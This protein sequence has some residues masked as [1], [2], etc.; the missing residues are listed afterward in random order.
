MKKMK[1]LALFLGLTLIVSCASKPKDP[2]EKKKLF[3]YEYDSVINPTPFAT[4]TEALD[5]IFDNNVLGKTTITI[6]RSEWDTMLKNYDSYYRN[7]IPVHADYMFEKG[8]KRWILSNAGFRLRGNTTRVRPQ[9]PDYSHSQGNHR[10]SNWQGL[11]GAGEDKYRQSSFKVSFDKFLPDDATDQ[12]KEDVKMAGFIKGVNLKRFQGDSAYIREIYSFDLLRGYGVWT[13]PRASYTRLFIQIFEDYTD[14]SYTLLN[15]GIYE[16]FEEIGKESLAERSKKTDDSWTSTKGNLWKC[17]EHSD[18]TPYSIYKPEIDIGIDVLTAN[19]DESQSYRYCL[20]SNKKDFDSAKDELVKWIEEL[21]AINV[22]EDGGP[23]KAKE[24][25]DSHMEVDLFLRTMA[26]NVILGMDD[27]YWGN[28]NNFY[29]YFDT[30]AKGSGK[31]YMIPFDY[32]H[33]FGNPVGGDPTNKNPLN[34]GKASGAR[35]GDRP[36]MEKM[37]AVPEYMEL[38]KKYLLEFTDPASR[39]GKEQSQERI[40]A[41]QALV[42]PYI[43][44]PSLIYDHDTTKR[45]IDNGGYTMNKYFLLSNPTIWEGKRKAVEKAI[46]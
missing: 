26:C 8:G 19:K 5:Y 39:F 12:Q 22:Y 38:Y 45:I 43:N 15:Y 37:I 3:E 4:D 29:L 44:S 35:P 2:N 17:Q 18:F 10:W 11:Q 42:E 14:G 30:S 33:T 27:D 13:A 32:D 6:P 7:E 23:E 1:F 31:L 46:K 25:F 9:G 28:G 41:W 36:L 40:K 20:K 16:M 24:W 34:W 21:A